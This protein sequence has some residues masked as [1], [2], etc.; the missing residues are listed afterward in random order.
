M[1]HNEPAAYHFYLTICLFLCTPNIFTETGTHVVSRRAAQHVAGGAILVVVVDLGVA[2]VGTDGDGERRL[3]DR[4]VPDGLGAEKVKGT[5]RVATA[6]VGGVK[7]EHSASGIETGDNNS[8]DVSSQPVL[9][10]GGKAEHSQAEEVEE[11]E[12]N[13]EHVGG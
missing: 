3:A 13:L 8:T 4:V 10:V 2:T 11:H 6:V 9:G 7:G 12:D 5:L 1:D